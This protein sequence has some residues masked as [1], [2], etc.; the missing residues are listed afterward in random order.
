M[1]VF[2]MFWL[3]VP[4]LYW[5]WTLFVRVINSFEDSKIRKFN[6]EN[7]FKN[8]TSIIIAKIN[9]DVSKKRSEIVNM[10]EKIFQKLPDWEKKISQRRDY[11]KHIYPY[12]KTNK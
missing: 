9:L 10:Q 2:G 3:W 1:V 8:E 4:L 12:K 11:Y 6:V 5:L 7:D